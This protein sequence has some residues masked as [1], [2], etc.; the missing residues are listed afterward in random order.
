MIF[1]GCY[2]P[3]LK[4]DIYAL[5]N[6]GIEI[7][8]YIQIFILMEAAFFLAGIE[9]S[10]LIIKKMKK[11][12]KTAILI[13]LTKNPVIIASSLSTLI[14]RPFQWPVPKNI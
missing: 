11:Q 10:N 9:R 7:L 4:D 6:I 2:T 8:M 12:S 1:V 13:K 5:R 3:R 14:K